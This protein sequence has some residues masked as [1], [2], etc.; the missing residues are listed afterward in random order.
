MGRAPRTSPAS[1]GP[2]SIRP[3]NALIRIGLHH[4]IGG[5]HHLRL[6]PLLRASAPIRGSAVLREALRMVVGWV[7]P[8]FIE[9]RPTR[10]AEDFG[11]PLAAVR[12]STHPTI[13]AVAEAGFRWA[14]R[15]GAAFDPPYDLG[16]RRGRIS[17]GLSPRCGVRPTL[18]SRLSPRQDFGGPLAAVRRSTHPTISAVAEAAAI[19]RDPG[20]RA[21]GTPGVRVRSACAGHWCQR[22]EKAAS[23][24]VGNS[25]SFFCADQGQLWYDR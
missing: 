22:R 16:C 24:Q 23:S 5:V 21:R 10:F 11:G 6:T 4:V 19:D 2:S 8:R 1:S 15:R 13:S 3:D 18:R 25:R 20:P 7:E 14:S 9:A 12:R 17:V